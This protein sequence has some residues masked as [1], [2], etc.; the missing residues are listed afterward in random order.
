M[1]EKRKAAAEAA[2]YVRRRLP[3]QPRIGMILGSGLGVLADDIEEAEE[4]EYGEIPGFPQSTVA[5]HAGKLVSGTLEDTPVLVFSG[6][7]HYYEGFSLDQVV[8]PIRL[9]RE[10]EIESVVIT[11]AAG[12]INRSLQAGDLMAIRDHLK[13]FDDSPLRGENV[14]EYGPRFNDLS[15]AYSADLRALAREAADEAGTDLREGVYAYMS[16]PSFETPA[17]IDMLRLLGADAVGMSTVPEVITAAHAGMKVLAISTIS[18]MAAGILDRPLTHEEVMETGRRVR[19][20][21]LSLLR[22]L[23]KRI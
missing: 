23:L 15:N 22:A 19:G 11:N 5:G 18:N 7:F 12:G 21:F 14:E 8:L 6:R 1:N 4:I 10:L 9:M 2:E 3:V 13:F 20:T 16:G 17:E